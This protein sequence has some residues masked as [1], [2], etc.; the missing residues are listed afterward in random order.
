MSLVRLEAVT[1]KLMLIAT[2]ILIKY[3]VW[4]FISPIVISNTFSNFVS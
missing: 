2:N 1:L 3:P 4:E